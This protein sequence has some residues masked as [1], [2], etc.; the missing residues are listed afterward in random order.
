MVIP[1]QIMAWYI[2][3]SKGIDLTHR[4]Y[5][6]FSQAVNSKTQVQDYV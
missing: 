5:T 3:K 4:I 1:F 6:D 2:A